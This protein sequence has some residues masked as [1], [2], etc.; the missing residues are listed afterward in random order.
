M[1][2]L[3]SQRRKEHQ[4]L[5]LQS[6]NTVSGRYK[7]FNKYMWGGRYQRKGR[8][9]K[10]EREKR[11]RGGGGIGG[12]EEEKEGKEEEGRKKSS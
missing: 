1:L 2:G 4:C 9:K 5:V 11:E 3:S 7:A 8:G 12:R 10:K 6:P